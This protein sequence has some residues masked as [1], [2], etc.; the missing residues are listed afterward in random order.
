MSCSP[1]D[2]IQDSVNNKGKKILLIMPFFLGEGEIK[3]VTE[4]EVMVCE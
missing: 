3:A 4:A 2:K 1:K